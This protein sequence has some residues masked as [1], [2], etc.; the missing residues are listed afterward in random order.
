MSILTCNLRYKCAEVRYNCAEVV[1]Q[2]T[3][4]SVPGIE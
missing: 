3:T 1:T 4:E 2:D